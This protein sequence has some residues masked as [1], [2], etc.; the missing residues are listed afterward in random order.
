MNIGVGGVLGVLKGCFSDFFGQSREQTVTYG[1]LSRTD[2]T[3]ASGKKGIA[4]SGGGKGYGW[5]YTDITTVTS[6][7]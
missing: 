1:V 6:P 3:T 7:L 5:S 4:V 2:I